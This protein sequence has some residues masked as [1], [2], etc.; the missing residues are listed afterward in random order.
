MTLKLYVWSPFATDY[1][2]G[3]AFAI[4]EN[5]EQARKLCAKHLGFNHSELS[6]LEP[7]VYPLTSP[8][9]FA[10]CGGG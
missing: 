4:A 10:V 5:I 8:I 1:T 2:D 9:G 3:L 7:R 6:D